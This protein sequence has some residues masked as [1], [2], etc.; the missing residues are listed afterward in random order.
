M[1]K[2][3]K[4]KI[5]MS[6]LI[7]SL[8]PIGIAGIIITILTLYM[9][10]IIGQSDP[11]IGLLNTI[12][13]VTFASIIVAIGLSILLSIRTA[14]K[15]STPLNDIVKGIRKVARGNLD[16][17]LSVESYEEL[18]LLTRGINVMVSDIQD[19]LKNY[20]ASEENAK[21]LAAQS[22]KISELKSNLITF[23]SHE[24]K[25]P[26]IPIVGWAELMQKTMNAD[27]SLDNLFGKEEIDGISRSAKKLTKIIEDFLDVGRIDSGKLKLEYGI[28]SIA[29]IMKNAI[30]TVVPSAQFTNISLSNEIQDENLWVDGF[31]IEQV[32]TN[33][34]TNAV[35]YSPPGTVVRVTS[36]QNQDYY[37]IFVTD[38]GVG[39]T[40]EQL[41]DIWQP[42]S[43]SYLEKKDTPIPGTGIGLFLVKSIIDA[44]NGKI[45]IISAGR[46]KG[47]TVKITFPKKD[48]SLP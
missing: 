19:L 31:R 4:T 27:K 48:I 40:T 44:H 36:E 12:V 32:F 28:W 26:L 2:S 18:K 42:F 34:L 8:L 5:V 22:L 3:I 33:L 24:L 11:L 20:K 35:K 46:N 13:L 39:F 37:T 21:R 10:S 45:E 43:T 29:Q 14:K 15:I 41:K 6:C 1:P 38:K 7:S 47:S 9:E 17:Q 30:E 25:T 23:A 16:Y